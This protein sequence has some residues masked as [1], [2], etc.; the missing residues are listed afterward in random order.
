M[1]PFIADRPVLSQVKWRRGLRKLHRLALSKDWSWEATRAYIAAFRRHRIQVVLAEYGFTGVAVAEACRLTNT[2]FVV[3]FHGYDASAQEILDEFADRY[4][5]MF[6]QTRAVIAVSRTMIEQL[7][8]LG[9]SRQKLVY[10]PYGVDCE[11]F[12]GSLPSQSEPVF[13]AVGRMIEKKA[14]HLTIL[15]FWKLLR[16]VPEARLRIVGGSDLFGVCRDLVKALGIEDAVSFL[17]FQNHERVQREMRQA[18]AFVQ[19]SVIAH[20]GDREGTPV[21][22]LEA[23]A[24]GLPVVAT[25]H[26]GIPDVVQDG[27]TGLLVDEHDIDGMANHMRTLALDA[28]LAAEMGRN[29]AQYTRRFFSTDRSIDRLGKILDAAAEATSIIDIEREI[30]AELRLARQ[31]LALS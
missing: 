20:N 14:P 22:V 26:A 25:R 17:G 5:A 28:D 8:H 23:A 2:P 29:A 13:L 31:G 16:E 9:C 18:R 27:Y 15:A 10:C 30:D 1:C 3:H 4:R 24:S 11:R 21:A 19:H 7:V 12:V 6:L